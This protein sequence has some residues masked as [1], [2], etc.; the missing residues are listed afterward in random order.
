MRT[1]LTLKLHF[2]IYCQS[3]QEDTEQWSG[4]VSLKQC[5]ALYGFASIKDLW[6]MDFCQGHYVWVNVLCV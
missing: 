5:Q 2:K 6:I 1:Q 4:Q 3:T